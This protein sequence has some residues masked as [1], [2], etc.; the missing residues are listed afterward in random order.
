MIDFSLLKPDL[1]FYENDYKGTTINTQSSFDF[2]VE[3]ANQIVW[4]H[5]ML[6]SYI[7]EDE[8]ASDYASIVK[9]LKFAQC[10]MAELLSKYGAMASAENRQV[11]SESAGK[12][13][14]NYA[15][16]SSEV[17]S[18]FEKFQSNIVKKYL[19]DTGLL[20]RGVG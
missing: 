10:N 12:V 5:I 20:Y 19:F 11:V 2:Y 13:S 16:V 15:D 14:V 7:L 8:T 18:N 6:N 17:A 9:K 1:S 3:Q 4:E